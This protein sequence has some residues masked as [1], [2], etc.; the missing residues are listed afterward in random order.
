LSHATPQ[1]D[2]AALNSSLPGPSGSA[3]VPF[4]TSR[5]TPAEKLLG[6]DTVFQSLKEVPPVHIID[7]N[8]LPAIPAI[9]HVI[10]RARMFHWHGARYGARVSG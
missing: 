4:L 3:G 6:E 1:N 8:I 7:E 10:D 5:R 9:H 2:P